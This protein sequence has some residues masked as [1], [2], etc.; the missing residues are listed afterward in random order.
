MNK[1][2]HANHW[3]DAVILRLNEWRNKESIENLH[4]DDMKTPSGR[5]HT[6]ALRGVVLHDLIAKTLSNESDSKIPNTYVFND[7]D[8]MDGLP[9]YLPAE[10]FEQYMGVPLY[11]I[12]APTIEESG[13]DFTNASAAEKKRYSEAKSFAE[14]YAFDFVDAFQR[15]GCSQEVIWSHELYESGKMDE[16]IKTAL[17]SIDK[18]RTIYKEVADYQLPDNWYPFQVTCPECGKVGTTLT[19]GWDGN[20]VTFEC[21]PDKVTWAKGCGH[22]GSISPFGG[23]GKLLWKV[24]WPGHWAA[25]GVTVEGAGKDHTSAGGSRDM[26]NALCENVFKIKPPFDIP[27]EWILIR[28]AKMSSSK[29]VGTSAREFVQ[30][31]PPT[32]GRFLFASKDYNQVIDFDPA[33]LSIP[34]LFDEYDQ[35]AR[36][37]WETE[38]GDKRLGRA[39]ELSQIGEIP[40]AHFLPRFRDLA[41]WMQHPEI[42]LVEQ[43]SEIAGAPLA[44]EEIEEL[45]MRRVYAEKWVEYYA[46]EEYQLRAKAEMPAAA[47]ELSAEQIA[48]LQKALNLI[49]EKEWDPADLQQALFELAKSGVG[50]RKAFQAIYLAFLG[51]KSGPRAAWFLLS[52]EPELRTKRIAELQNADTE[53]VTKQQTDQNSLISDEV[54]QQF[55]GISF[56]CVKISGVQIQKTNTELQELTKKVLQSLTVSTT[57]EVTALAPVQAYRKLLKATGTDF[58]SKRPSPEALLRRIVQGK[59]LYQINTAVDAYNLAVLET[60]I[61]LGGFDAAQLAG[62]VQLRFSKENESMHLLGDEKPTLTREGQLVYADE[63][64][65]ITIDLN[66]RD[67]D[68]TKITTDTTNILL[69]ADGAPNLA[70]EDI[71]AALQKGAEYIQQFCGGTIETIRMNR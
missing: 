26:A 58:H 63:E 35:G 11:K 48:F 42:D 29:G 23:T 64:K 36:I 55:P 15:L 67:I 12:P 66:Y 65:A 24:D 2:Q 14:F 43:F 41:L 28:G 21:Q 19:T 51:K 32:I 70:E 53:V 61:G 57:E 47:K 33:T 34:D 59:N 40:T 17:D 49:E 31:F 60:G 39:F 22:T 3:V 16:I 9:G 1:T 8:P 54:R 62:E 69:Y 50:P 20:E 25:L 30:L 38:E 44:P 10:K 37:F 68:A 7:M 4:V 6:G 52:I 13:V 27:Y 71:L 18:I 46:P 56:A 45:E 5:V